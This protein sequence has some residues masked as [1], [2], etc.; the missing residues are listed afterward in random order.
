MDLQ[1]SSEAG[2]GWKS[3]QSLAGARNKKKV[4]EELTRMTICN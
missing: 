3:A 2:Q 4:M 1:D